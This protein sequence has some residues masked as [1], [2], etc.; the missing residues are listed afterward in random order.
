MGE[1]LDQLSQLLSSGRGELWKYGGEDNGDNW[2]CR[3]EW[4]TG[5][6][7]GFIGEELDEDLCIGVL[8][9]R[10]RSFVLILVWCLGGRGLGLEEL[11]WVF[12]KGEWGESQSYES[13]G[14]WVD[15]IIAVIIVLK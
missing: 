9:F 7:G 2:E 3:G 1:S 5:E 12:A 15:L 6:D 11:V 13:D 14:E 4:R 8:F 10:L